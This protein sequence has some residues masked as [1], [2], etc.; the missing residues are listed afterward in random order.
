VNERLIDRGRLEET[1]GSLVIIQKTIPGLS[2][3]ALDR[4]VLAARRAAGLRGRV[5]VVITSSAAL[6]GLNQKFRG[7]NEPT[8]VLSFPTPWAGR[9]KGSRLAG[10]IAISADIAAQNAVQLGHDAK[11]EVK[12]LALHGVLHLAGFDHERDNGKMARKEASLREKLRLPSGLIERADLAAKE[13]LG[14]RG[15]KTGTGRTA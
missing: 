7:K 12:I 14:R 6:R 4:F 11:Q 5:N 10:D 15:S 1:W 8:D 9:A 3:S 2:E 13:A